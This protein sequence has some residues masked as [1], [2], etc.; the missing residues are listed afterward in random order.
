[1]GRAALIRF[2]QRAKL[3]RTPFPLIGAASLRADIAW[4]PAGWI[5]EFLTALADE[6]ADGLQ[7]LQTQERA[8]FAARSL[9][10]GRRSTSRAGAAIDILAAAPLVS[11]TSLG[12]ALGMA[13]QNAAHLLDRFCADGIAIEVTHRSKRRL[14]GLAALAPLRD[15]VAPPRR[16]EPG[17]GRGRSPLRPVEDAVTAPPAPLPPLTPL[18][19]RSLDYS[20]LDAA[21]AFADEAMRNARR[22]LGRLRAG[23]GQSV[24]APEGDAEGAASDSDETPGEWLGPSQE[25][26]DVAGG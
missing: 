14:Y 4:A 15:G 5:P 12:R 26:A 6:A 10:G 16:P 9:A 24:E 13:T 3:L 2:W 20:G 25:P 17:R 11:A 22:V 1:V 18:E 21:M 23:P 8:W 19:R 7:L